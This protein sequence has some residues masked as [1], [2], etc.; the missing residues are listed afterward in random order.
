MVPLCPPNPLYYHFIVTPWHPHSTSDDKHWS[1]FRY[2]SFFSRMSNKLNQMVC[3]LL[4]L[5][6]FSALSLRFIQ[7]MCIN[8]LFLFTEQLWIYHSYLSIPP[9]K[10]ILIVSSFCLSQ[11][12]FLWTFIYSF[13]CE[14]RFSFLWHKYSE[15]KFFGHI[16]NVYLTL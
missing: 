1:V 8:N 16:V 3:T 5:A 13:L 15:V 9:L 12:N 7:V 2:Y 14:C 11:M 6:S 10:D 4:W